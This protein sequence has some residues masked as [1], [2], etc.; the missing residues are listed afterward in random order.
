MFIETKYVD[1][2]QGDMKKCVEAVFKHKGD[3]VTAPCTTEKTSNQN[4]RCVSINIESNLRFAFVKSHLDEALIKS[5]NFGT[6]M[7]AVNNFAS[8]ICVT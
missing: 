3:F 4:W 7:Y 5:I 1:V 6:K 2:Q 8:G